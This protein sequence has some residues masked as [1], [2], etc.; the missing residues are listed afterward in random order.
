MPFRNVTT[1]SKDDDDR[2]RGRRQIKHIL[3]EQFC[4][5]QPMASLVDTL[6]FRISPSKWTRIVFISI[7]N[8]LFSVA[9]RTTTTT[10]A[11]PLWMA[12]TST[13][14]PLTGIKHTH[15]INARFEAAVSKRALR[16]WQ[17]HRR[18]RRR[19]HTLSE[20][21]MWHILCDVQKLNFHKFVKYQQII[22]WI[23]R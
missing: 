12:W 1:A 5:H 7:F 18:R 19:S 15:H 23:Y 10:M 13:R 20:F 16:L 8:A 3:N 9:T 2:V 4:L 6:M 17:H 11:D 14:L 22:D 21:T